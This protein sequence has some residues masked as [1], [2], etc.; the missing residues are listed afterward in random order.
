MV[1]QH[2][3]F[4]AIGWFLS[5][6]SSLDIAR[7]QDLHRQERQKRQQQAYRQKQWARDS[8]N[9]WLLYDRRW[10]AEYLYGGFGSSLTYFISFARINLRFLGP[11]FWLCPVKLP[12]VLLPGIDWVLP[13]N[14][15][16][17]LCDWAGM[18][19]YLENVA[20][21]TI[22]DGFWYQLSR[23]VSQSTSSIVTP[24][25]IGASLRTQ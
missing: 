14:C 6:G 17:E 1:G 12:C 10:I 11:A 8:R 22:M 16:R 24:V 15:C 7:T 9:A 23:L 21:Y 13:C 2:S 4:Q 19:M 25:S 20:S 3:E 18:Y 5:G